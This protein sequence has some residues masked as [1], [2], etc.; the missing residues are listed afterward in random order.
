MWNYVKYNDHWFVVD[1][2]FDDT[3]GGPDEYLLVG[4]GKV[5]TTHVEGN[6]F[7]YPSLCANSVNGSGVIGGDPTHTVTFKVNGSTYKEKEVLS[8]RAVAIPE[9]PSLS[10]NENFI[11]W[12]LEGET[13]TYDFSTPV[14][15]DITLVAYIVDE[16]VFKLIYD[17]TGGSK[18]QNTVVLVAENTTKITNSVPIKEGFKFKEWNTSKDGKGISYKGGEDITLVGDCTLY[19]IWEDTSSVSFKIDNVVDK[20]AEFLSK[21]TIPGV[22]N[23]L[24]TIG[25]ITTV[26]SLLA[27]LAIARK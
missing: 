6:M 10:F 19:A 23:L 17:S 25:V 9:E 12:R 7:T 26:V 5:D 14:S 22:S 15:S 24:L 1:C 18:I 3:G 2:T 11:E 27:V 4:T 8:G 21:E 16:P 20:A 13:E